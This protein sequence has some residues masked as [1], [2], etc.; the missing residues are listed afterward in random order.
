[1]NDK[2]DELENKKNIS[3]SD[4]EILQAKIDDLID[5]N[6]KLEDVFEHYN[7]IIK[8]KKDEIYSELNKFKNNIEDDMHN[9]DKKIHN[10]GK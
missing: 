9:F 8:E 4:K 1:M 2:L 10:Q 7:D 3:E 6:N 5:N